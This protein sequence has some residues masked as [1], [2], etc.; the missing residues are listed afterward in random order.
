MRLTLFTDYSLR[1][2]M[3][4]AALDGKPANIQEI[5]D[6]YGISKNHML[7]VVR[8]LAKERF[9][10]TQRGRMGGLRLARS[11]GEIGVGEVVRRTEETLAIAECMN[12]GV[13]NCLLDDLCRLRGVFNEAQTN[14]LRTLDRYT[15]ADLMIPSVARRLRAAEVSR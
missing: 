10:R 11:P 3:Y 12:S 15:V 8:R 1:T 4:L 14:F 13:H 9:I 6:H 7:K 2:L 5:A